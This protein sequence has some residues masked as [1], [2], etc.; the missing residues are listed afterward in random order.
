MPVTTP[1]LVVPAP[2]DTA[3]MA[4]HVEHGRRKVEWT[5]EASGEL[6]RNRYV[7]AWVEVRE[8]EPWRGDRLALSATRRPTDGSS[9]ARVGFTPAAC[10]RLHEV[11]VPAVA[12]YGFNRLWAGLHGARARPDEA[13]R[14]ADAAR[15]E[16]AWWDTKADLSEMHAAGAIELRP[17]GP[18]FGPR[19]FTQEVACQYGDRRKREPVAAEA[20][21]NGGRVGWV[22]RRGELIP[23]QSILGRHW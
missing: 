8:T 11:L 5:L 15:A 19:E 2:F 4:A 10:H 3:P 18:E 21:L 13:R 17:L 1:A 16:A 22:T 23:D 6:H 9:W 20:H 12:R 14:G 7:R